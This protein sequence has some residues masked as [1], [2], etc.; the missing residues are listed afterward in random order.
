MTSRANARGGPL[1]EP[2]LLSIVIKAFN[3]EKKIARA[4]ESALTAADELAPLRVEVVLADSLSSDNTVAVA[5]RYTV[6]IVQL[7]HAQ[8]RGC[9]AGVQL[10]YEWARGEWVYLMDGDTR[11]V[12]LAGRTYAEGLLEAEI[13]ERQRAWPSGG[14]V[15]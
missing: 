6:N 14:E 2:G 10:G 5:S 15:Q 1:S 3:E 12:Q 9:G 11:V 4:I 7:C 13:Q 8:D